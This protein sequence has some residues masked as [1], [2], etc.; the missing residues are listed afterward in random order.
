DLLDAI[1]GD[2]K[3]VPAVE[4]RSGVRP[5]IDRAWR[6]PAARIE[7]DQLVAGRKPDVPAVGRQ[8]MPV[9]DAG[10]GPILADDF[11]FGSFHAAILEHDPEKWAPVFGKDHAPARLV[12]RERT[13]E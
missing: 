9:V 5:N 8:P 11:G 6:L 13:R 2:L 10:E 12:A 3:E 1:L 4:G 7:G